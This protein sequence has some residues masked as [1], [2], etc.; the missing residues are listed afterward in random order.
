MLSFRVRDH[1]KVKSAIFDPMTKL[2]HFK[3]ILCHTFLLFDYLIKQFGHILSRM[4]ISHLF[5]NCLPTHTIYDIRNLINNRNSLRAESIANIPR[6]CD[7]L[8][9]LQGL[10]LISN[11]FNTLF[12][13]CFRPF[14]ILK[15]KRV[16][17]WMLTTL[18]L[19]ESSQVLVIKI[20]RSTH[21]PTIFSLNKHVF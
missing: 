15:I 3:L 20:G 11:L 16:A 10:Y 17:V 2:E 7:T 19:L 14:R 6:Q 9:L 21:I 8:Q 5:R 12:Q 18:V 13:R 4:L 1:I